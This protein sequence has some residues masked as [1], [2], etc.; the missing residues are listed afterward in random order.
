MITSLSQL[1]SRA[2]NKALLVALLYH[3]LLELL[4]IFVLLTLVILRSLV[5]QGLAFDARQMTAIFGFAYSIG[6]T[7]IR[8]LDV[9]GR[10]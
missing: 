4:L 7:R 6:D 3:C 5:E 8:V 9:R 1:D 10:M 2:T